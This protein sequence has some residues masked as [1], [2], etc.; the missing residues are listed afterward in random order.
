MSATSSISPALAETSAVRSGR[1]ARDHG[2]P[3][4]VVGGSRRRTSETGSTHLGR[5]WAWRPAT[6]SQWRRYPGRWLN[7]LLAPSSLAALGI[8]RIVYRVADGCDGMDVDFLADGRRT[9]RPWHRG[10]DALSL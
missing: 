2:G 10:R 5:L 8:D 3:S 4:G 7:R 6:S 9:S 1:P